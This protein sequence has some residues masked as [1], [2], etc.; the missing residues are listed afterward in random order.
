MGKNKR[1]ISK[2]R[3]VWRQQEELVKASHI[4]VDKIIKKFG[5]KDLK[6]ILAEEEIELGMME[7]DLDYAEKSNEKGK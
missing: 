6:E 7:L 2:I 3:K 1:L 4:A 5:Y